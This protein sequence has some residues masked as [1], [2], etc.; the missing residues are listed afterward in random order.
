MVAIGC[1][2]TVHSCHIYSEMDL[3][4]LLGH[5]GLVIAITW[6]PDNQWIVTAA[7]DLTVRLWKLRVMGS[8]IT[9]QCMYVINDLLVL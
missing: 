9:T 3:P 5:T 8:E 6:L 2:E 1:G 4:K 7:N